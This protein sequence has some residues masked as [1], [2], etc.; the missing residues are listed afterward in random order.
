MVAHYIIEGDQTLINHIYKDTGP[1][2][3]VFL[4][5]VEKVFN[6]SEN[7]M[8]LYSCVDHHIY[9]NTVR[10]RFCHWFLYYNKTT[11]EESNTVLY[12]KKG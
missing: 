1:I 6:L 4:I 3:E 11:T 7:T 9:S 5:A 8:A 12:S 10:R 2:F